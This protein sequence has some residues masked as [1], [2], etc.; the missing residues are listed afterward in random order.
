MYSIQSPTC[1]G[2]LLRTTSVAF[3]LKKFNRNSIYHLVGRHW[4]VW[5][6]Q[7]LQRHSSNVS[8]CQ[9][10]NTGTFRTSIANCDIRF[11]KHSHRKRL[12]V[13]FHDL[14]KKSVDVFCFWNQSH[15]SCFSSFRC[16]RSFVCSFRSFRSFRSFL[17]SNFSFVLHKGSLAFVLL[18][19]YFEIQKM[20]LNNIH[21]YAQLWLLRVSLPSS[22]EAEISLPIGYFGMWSCG[23]FSKDPADVVSKFPAIFC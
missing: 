18:R 7:L 20:I 10:R 14:R 13:V 6:R 8:T 12:P 17:V 3:V 4:P 9:S 15:V 19:G 23:W 22:W 16:F 2:R 5:P 21:D 11:S 1:F